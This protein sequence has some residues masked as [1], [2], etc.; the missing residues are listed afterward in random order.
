MQSPVLQ[1]PEI[2]SRESGAVSHELAETASLG[3][4]A[5]STTR[6]PQT[7]VASLPSSNKL[8]KMLATIILLLTCIPV[9][10][11]IY[12]LY[13]VGANCAGNDCVRWIGTVDSI[14]SR[15]FNWLDLPSV[16][17][18]HPHF[19]LI[20][21]LIELAQIFA[22][23]WDIRTQTL[24]GV[25]LLAVSTILQWDMLRESLN[26]RV[27]LAL[28]A[29]IVAVN[30]STTQYSTMLSGKFSVMIS[31]LCLLGFTFS[32]WALSKYRSF[33]RSS[34]RNSSFS[35]GN[36]S[37][38]LV[39]M[40][41]GLV[42][43]AYSWG[44]VLPASVCTLVALLGLG[45][46]NKRA[47]AAWCI[48]SFIA[49]A[50]YAFFISEIMMRN[51]TPSLGEGDLNLIR[52]L[53][54]IGR[55][56]SNNIAVQFDRLPQSIETG[57]AGCIAII[58]MVSYLV[59]R[60]I[61]F[62]GLVPLLSLSLYS[63]INAILVASTRVHIAPW[64]AVPTKFIWL[65]VVT[66]SIYCISQVDR[67]SQWQ[68]SRKL[69][70][71]ETILP[72]TLGVI[73]LSLFTWRYVWV[74]E[75]YDD[76]HFYLKSR[77]PASESYQRNYLT[78]PT[79]GEPLI[80]QWLSGGANQAYAHSLGSVLERHGLLGLGKVQQRT[81]QG[82]YFLNNVQFSQRP[83]ISLPIW[84]DGA[85]PIHPMPWHDYHHLDMAIKTPQVVTWRLTLP[86][87]S[88]GVL[89]TACCPAA[90]KSN[91]SFGGT[92]ATITI[93]NTSKDSSPGR[94]VVI[95][96]SLDRNTTWK[97]MD[98]KLD[99]FAGKEVEI[100]FSA[101]PRLGAAASSSFPHLEPDWIVFQYPRIDL[102]LKDGTY[103][104][105]GATI[106]NKP[107]GMISRP[108]NTDISP[109]FP[110]YKDSGTI[111]NAVPERKNAFEGRDLVIRNYSHVQLSANTHGGTGAGALIL[112]F[113]Y[114]NYP[115][116]A[117]VLP[118]LPD[119]K[120]HAYTYDFKLLQAPA[121]AKLKSVEFHSQHEDQTIQ[122]SDVRLLK[123]FL[124]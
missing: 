6:E 39:L 119:A 117:A 102:V 62:P 118:L 116:F 50:P 120:E 46:R 8:I 82:D 74:N 53:D 16:S 42:I 17:Y 33:E 121:D 95:L 66:L 3:S 29:G 24:I 108:C 90:I 27:Q 12:L 87:E 11:S 18:V 7:E 21:N 56:L 73:I 67:R 40:A 110:G 86:P 44:T 37:K 106:P 61:R 43:S 124:N 122:V 51:S 59:S 71:S 45:Y 5:D 109:E 54:V 104:T 115:D 69:N 79:Y 89:R 34:F 60:K 96:R 57:T 25:I 31:G 1:S 83:D 4:L 32:L 26:K 77:A 112:T 84:A 41:I 72:A 88:S 14:L 23:V 114:T 58:C 94:S 103:G 36:S 81:L 10:R 92:N 2:V 91:D 76:K 100:Q 93:R 35:S 38:A 99:Q 9:A 15:T 80:F 55:P 30:F 75:S 85:W 49:W 64:Y 70:F 97:S 98:Q 68:Q 28:L 13:N 101:T 65:A 78:A 105:N 22:G 47:I 111:L 19:I 63:L 20:P 52:I 107:A 123:A 113:K 48:A